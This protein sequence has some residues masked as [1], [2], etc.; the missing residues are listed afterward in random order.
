MAKAGSSLTNPIVRDANRIGVQAGGSF[1][2]SDVTGTPQTSPL[3]YTN[4]VI[5]IVVPDNAIEC[6]LNPSTALRVSELVGMA[7]YDVIAANTK[8]S[9]PCAAMQNIYIT[10]DSVSGTVGFR[11]TIL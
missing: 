2:T 3:A 11:F 1:V 4:A 6:I 5:T 10:R 7:Q 8:E 9:I